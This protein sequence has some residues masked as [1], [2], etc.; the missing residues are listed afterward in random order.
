M[1]PLSKSTI[2]CVKNRNLKIRGSR[3]RNPY[4]NFFVEYTR[5]N[6]NVKTSV[7]AKKAGQEWCNL[8]GSEKKIYED[9]SARSRYV[10][11]SKD[12]DLNKFLKHLRRCFCNTFEIDVA[13]LKATICFLERWKGKVLRGLKWLEISF[14]L[15]DNRHLIRCWVFSFSSFFG[16]RVTIICT[17]F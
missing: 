14:K 8:R 9:M 13:E 10:Y 2:S 6:K 1:P 4:V 5:N 12:K 3:S 16:F 7:A 15:N 11:R 17:F